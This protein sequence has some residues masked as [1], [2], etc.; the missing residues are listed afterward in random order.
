MEELQDASI[1]HMTAKVI[2]AIKNTKSYEPIYKEL[3]KLV[4]NP[5]V[6]THDMRNTLEDAIKSA[7]LET[8][9][10]NI[11][12]NL[13]RT[14]LSRT[15]DK[16]L[17]I[18]QGAKPTVSDP[19]GYL[20]RAGVLWDRRVRKSLNAMCTE[21][22][23]PLHGQPRISADREDFMAKW[24][25]LSNYNMD[26]ANYRPVYAPKDLLEVLLSLKGPAKTTENTDQIPQWEFS[27]IALPVKNLFELR[28]HYA[29]LLR[30]DS[31]LGVPD[32]TVQCQRIL[33]ARHAPMCQQFL[34]K[35]C[36]PAPYRGALWASVLDSKLHDYDIEYWQKLRNAV[37]TTDHIVDKLVFKDIQ[38]TASN[39]D[40]YFVF[41]DVLYQVL[42]CFSRDTDIGG[43]VEYETFPVKGKTYE[44]P[45]SGVVPFHGI[46]M[47]AAPFCY[48]YD[49]PVSLYYTFRAFYIRY[50]HRLTT[51]NTHPQGIVSLCLL[52][53]K[54]LQTYEPQLWSHFREL[55]IQPLRVVFKWLMRAFSGHLPPDQLL[56][57][58]DL[59]L[60][61]DSLE[62]L[63]L[64]A[65]IILSF[66]KESIM[67][68]ASLDSIEAIL[69]DLSSIKVL[70]LVQLALS[71]D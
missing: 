19:L 25:E 18:K 36:T 21:L 52:F 65:I 57:L 10:R 22:K 37:W 70:P 23:V 24:N 20:K 61:F 50:C 2:A 45:P 31:Y 59:I 51:I 35:G 29:D 68:V 43:C 26:L 46:C 15:D 11:V 54:L 47:F 49:S 48:L 62:I 41:E 27:H 64:F 30:S 5:S 8:E 55:Q 14:R 56:V 16:N 28:A 67:Q 3:Q 69:A 42:L 12:Y 17:A 1:H 71:R 63:P 66:R 33:E 60:G 58:W 34:K 6:D 44:G 32:L 7:G 53:E 39:D 9:I 4:C 38:L 13:V 40:Q